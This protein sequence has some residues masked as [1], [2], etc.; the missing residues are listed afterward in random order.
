MDTSQS[1]KWTTNTHIRSASGLLGIFV[2]GE[3]TR[4][5]LEYDIVAL[6]CG[7]NPKTFTILAGLK[8]S[9]YRSYLQSEES[10]NENNGI[11]L[12]F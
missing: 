5:T 6:D 9:I 10:E 12:W 7:L 1:Y 11:N 4:H 2:K 8:A 3:I